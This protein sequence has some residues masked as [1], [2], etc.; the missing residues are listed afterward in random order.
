MVSS[1]RS[2]GAE[3]EIPRL[4]TDK[5]HLDARGGLLELYSPKS[6]YPGFVQTNVLGTHKRGFR[7]L[8]AHKSGRQVKLAMCLSGLL[9]Y[10]AVDVRRS[11][12]NF[13]IVYEYMLYPT[14]RLYIP[15]GFAS[16]FLAVEDSDSL[17]CTNMVYEPE[18]ELRLCVLD[19]ELGLDW[20]EE[21]LIMSEK[22]RCGGTLDEVAI[23]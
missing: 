17:Y 19:P 3:S 16:G 9:N 7:G 12:P 22:D 23:P 18:N 20:N 1:L 11:S 10:V 2:G 6:G 4:I 15:A 14:H 8:H 5:L 13:G 21:D